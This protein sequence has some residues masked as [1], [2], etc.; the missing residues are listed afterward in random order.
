[1]KKTLTTE[2]KSVCF[3]FQVHQPYRLSECSFFCDPKSKDFFK[4]P[5]DFENEAVFNKVADKCY[6]PATEML[7]ELVKNNPEFK[8][9]FSFS[10]VFLEQCEQFAEKGRQ[11]L[12][13]FRELIKTGRVEIL[14]ETY[15]HSLAFLYSKL[16]FSE[17]IKLHAKKIKELFGVKPKVFRNTELIYSNEIAEFVR[18]MG[19][20]GMLAEGWDEHMQIKNPNHLRI[21]KN[22]LL[23]EKDFKIAQKHAISKKIPEHLPVLL[24]NYKLSDDIAF[25]FSNH[26]WNEHPL[27]IEKFAHWLEK[28]EGE[29]INLFMD[30]ETIGEHQWEETGIFN[31]FRAL[32]AELAKKNI[33]FH[34]PSEAIK[35]LQAKEEYD[36]HYYLSWADSERDISA[37]VENDIQRSA[38][39]E[40][41]NLE[42]IISPYRQSKNKKIQKILNDFRKLQ[43]SDHFYYMC[44]KYWNDG[45]VHKYF[46]PYDSPYEAYITFMNT[47][48]AFKK[49]LETEINTK[50]LKKKPHA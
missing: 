19:Y 20:Q 4:G 44:T 5:Q 13:L 7:L 47:V 30:Y 31:F 3:Y 23:N 46:S 45:D 9:S 2:K 35:K 28:A 40:I 39:E 14:A 25:R 12:D 50:N 6:L 16:E 34:T 43:T 24:K 21:A 37:W 18:Q 17:Q 22:I 8:I 49:E 11:V 42:K 1:M 36:V 32:P 38:L 10:G 15:Y 29:T 33:G 48:R 41:S 27:F 26:S